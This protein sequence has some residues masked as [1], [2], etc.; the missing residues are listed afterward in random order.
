MGM[1]RAF[2][3]RYRAPVSRTAWAW[4]VKGLVGVGVGG[5][6]FGGVGSACGQIEPLGG[7]EVSR[8]P[9]WIEVDEHPTLSVSWIDS[10]GRTHEHS[11]KL[12]YTEAK[13][14]V[15]VDENLEVYVSVG[16]TRLS[17][18]AGNPLGVVIRVGF[19]KADTYAPIFGSIDPAEP[20]KIELHGVRFKG[21]AVPLPESIMQHLSY[22]IDDIVACGLSK[23]YANMYNMASEVETLNHKAVGDRGRAGIIRTDI[24]DFDGE[25]VKSR[26]AG[27]ARIGIEPDG[28]VSLWASLPYQLLRHRGDPSKLDM[29]GTF[30][31]PYYFHLEF[32]AVPADVAESEFGIE[33]SE[34]MLE[35]ASE[36]SE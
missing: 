20:I 8:E 13:E 36:A 26:Q 23:E 19:Y 25:E 30:F 3:R 14:R 12:P 33:R 10:T 17:S 31:E 1:S 11:V 4:L 2:Y 16:G 5:A 27:T 21:D 9:L 15:R 7:S 22:A 32:E 35:P 28:S 34:M 18:G 24:R 29:P 6:V